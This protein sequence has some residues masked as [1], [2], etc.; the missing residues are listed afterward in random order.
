[1]RLLQ[2]RL[3]GTF[4]LVESRPAPRNHLLSPDDWT[5]IHS[6]FPYFFVQVFI[7]AYFILFVRLYD[8][9]RFGSAQQIIFFMKGPRRPMPARRAAHPAG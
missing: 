8:L 4:S 2:K 7:I 9:S 1:M 6:L 5:D 3:K